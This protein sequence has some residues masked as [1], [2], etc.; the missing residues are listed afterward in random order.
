[1]IRGSL[2]RHRDFRQ[3]WAGE[4][5]SQFGTSISHV[6]LPLVAVGALA[7]TPFEM[8]LLSAAET[9]AFLLIGL[10][11]GAWVDRMR[12]R[13]LM[14]RA[15]L[16]RALLLAS[17][18]LAWWFDVLT[19]PHLLL[20]AL[21]TGVL[22]VFF[23]VAYQSYL[24]T[25]VGREH[26]VEGNAKLETS[27]AVAQVSGPALG[28][29]IV[30]LV[31]AANAVLITGFGYLLSALFLWRIRAPEQAPTRPAGARLRTEIGE[32]LRFVLG[33]PLL[34]AI[35][36]CTASLNFFGSIS[37]ALLVLFLSRELGLSESAVGAV[38]ACTGVGSC[39]GAFTAT[40]WS[41]T[42]GQA[43]TIWLVML[44][45]LPFGLLLP[46]A[47]P[48]WAAVLAGLALLTN[49]YG[50]VVYNV[51]QVSFRQT[52][53][54]DHLLGRMNASIRFLVWGVLP[55]GSLFGGV[56]GE[57]LSVRGALWVAAAGS[58]LA[59][60]WLLTS[61]LRGMRDLPQDRSEVTTEA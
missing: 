16:G 51:A 28:G 4:T 19:L 15:D 38:L 6:A 46:L 48:G 32:G 10:P 58:F 53:C 23:D 33:N 14:L 27:R 17:V 41:R 43:R 37:T 1:M 8:G 61:P 5:V 52:I 60:V 12:R 49:T 29:G 50:G 31:S 59:L 24:P 22:T 26:L 2:W 55:L 42:F 18:P 11:A 45:T 44:V 57:W 39:L 47:R 13:P 25:L 20:V 34:R 7:A 9:V 21:L 30:Q 40:W 56:L 36:A 3:L 54:P 35:T